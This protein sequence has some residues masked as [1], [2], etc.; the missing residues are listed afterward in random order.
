MRDN[1]EVTS[2]EGDEPSA[3]GECKGKGPDPRNWGNLKLS[4]NE[5]DPDV[6]CTALALWNTANRLANE[7]DGDQPRLSKGNNPEST[8]QPTEDELPELHEKQEEGD[9]TLKGTSKPDKGDG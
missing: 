5:I 8:A 3:K 1:P 2:S 7:S 6:Q 4:K 9:Q